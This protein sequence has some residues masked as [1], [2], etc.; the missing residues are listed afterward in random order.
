MGISTDTGNFI[1]DSQSTRVL[2]TATTL[3]NIGAD[4]EFYTH[5]LYRSTDP[6]ALSTMT[7]MLTN[8]KFENHILLT[9]RDE[10][11]SGPM[12]KTQR[13]VCS[14]FFQKIDGY[15]VFVL[16]T[17]KDDQTIK[18]SL[19]SKAAPGKTAVNVS[20]LSQLYFHGGG[21]HMAA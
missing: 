2:S 14:S 15:D 3:I 16:G 17:I 18:L 12:S 13:E 20:E 11:D 21:H 1:Y 4:K 19:R 7:Q 6:Q 10:R 8:Y 9:Y 5:H